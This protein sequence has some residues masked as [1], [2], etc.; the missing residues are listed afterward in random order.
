MENIEQRIIVALNRALFT[1][2]NE[3]PYDTGNLRNNAIKL[4]SLGEGRWRIY[5]DENIAPYMPFTNEPWEHKIITMGNFRK[6]E[7]VRRMRTWDNPN[8]GW[9]DRA[10]QVVLKQIA[11][12]LGGRLQEVIHD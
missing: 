5:V 11:A 10:I 4:E 2:K 3:S 1:L 9:F 6:G 7:T 8:E 12:E